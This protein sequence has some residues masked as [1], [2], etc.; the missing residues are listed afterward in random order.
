MSKKHT[1]FNELPDILTADILS[2]FL[3]LSKRRVYELMDI[4]PEYGGIKCLRIGRNKRVLKTD[5]EEWMS[6]RTI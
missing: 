5:L 3:S 2:E 1:K 4:N 6:S